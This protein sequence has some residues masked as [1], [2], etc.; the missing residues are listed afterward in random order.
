MCWG[1]LMR[2]TTVQHSTYVRTHAGTSWNF[3]C[4]SWSSCNSSSHLRNPTKITKIIL[5]LHHDAD[6]KKITAF[7]HCLTLL[8][9]IRFLNV[10]QKF[11]WRFYDLI[12]YE[13]SAL[14]F[15]I[16]YVEKKIIH[17]FNILFHLKQRFLK[18]FVSLTAWPEGKKNSTELSV[19]PNLS[20][21]WVCGA[22]LG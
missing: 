19:C 18:Q 11:F 20:E 14:G 8:Y 7:L 17:V 13:L 10:Q 16:N 4:M 12:Y 9:T 3:V 15:C 5:Y 2:N 6:Q 1:C 21:G 22:A